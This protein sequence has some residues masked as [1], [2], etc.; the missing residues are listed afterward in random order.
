SMAYQPKEKSIYFI[1][2]DGYAIYKMDLRSQ[3]C[4]PVTIHNLPQTFIPGLLCYYQD[5]IC[6]S[7]K[8]LGLV[9]SLNPDT[10]ASDG[11]S[12]G[13][14]GK[15][16]KIDALASAGQSLYALPAADDADKL[17]MQIA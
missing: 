14:V 16:A 9:Y 11:V 7:D 4:S 6:V 5:H 1:R 10:N 2:G 17:W 12:L 15:G 13:L 3:L 8:G